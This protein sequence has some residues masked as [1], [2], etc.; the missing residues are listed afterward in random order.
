MYSM[1]TD[2]PNGGIINN[3]NKKH[4][5]REKYRFDFQFHGDNFNSSNSISCKR[6]PVFYTF[7]R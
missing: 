5:R 2:V 7:V 6:T 3:M 1:S 4:T